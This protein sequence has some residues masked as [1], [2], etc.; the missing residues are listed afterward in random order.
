MSLKRWEKKGK[1]QITKM[2]G[3]ALRARGEA[4]ELPDFSELES[5][6]LVRQQNQFGDMLLGSPVFRAVRQRALRARIDLVTGPANHECV[7]ACAHLD[8]VML[9]DKVAYLRN[10]KAAKRFTERLR[11]A[12]YELVLVLSTVSFSYTSGWLAALSGARWRAGR[13]G[14]NGSGASTADDL[15]H[16]VLP[17]PVPERHQT[18]VNLDLVTPFGASDA[19]WT[20]EI[21]LSPESERAGDHALFETLGTIG[22]GLRIVM[23]PGAGKKP[24]RWPA[25]RFGQVA[26]TLEDAGHRVAIT[27]GPSE[28]GLFD[29]VDAGAGRELPRLPPLGLHALAGALKHADFLMANDTGV[30]HLGASA[31]VPILALFGPTDP[32]QWCPAAP[33]VWHLRGDEDDVANL[34]ID[35]VSEACGE[36]VS[37]LDGGRVPVTPN[38]APS[39]TAH[40]E[41]NV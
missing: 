9:Y 38:E 16:W 8:E 31:G 41:V 18:G 15:F 19:D 13:P 3:R 32:A 17:E 26:R 33:R 7:R 27:T 34:S 25:E 40:P 29:E 6:L 21:H 2:L 28:T 14:P 39:P 20:P 10:P 4:P 35:V 37:H 30:L 5:I 22:N 23:H 1:H 24:N 11:G 12:R 36:I